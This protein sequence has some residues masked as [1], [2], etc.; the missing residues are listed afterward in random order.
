MWSRLIDL[1]FGEMAGEALLTGAWVCHFLALEDVFTENVQ[2]FNDRSNLVLLN[3]LVLCSIPS[4]IPLED[5]CYS[6]WGGLVSLLPQAFCVKKDPGCTWCILF[7]KRHF[8]SKPNHKG[9]LRAGSYGG[10][11]TVWSQVSV[12]YHSH[13]SSALTFHTSSSCCMLTWHS[14]STFTGNM[15]LEVNLSLPVS[16]QKLVVSQRCLVLPF[17]A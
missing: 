16:L 3:V 9:R 1:V 15:S 5:I 7:L 10:T 11:R 13:S 8:H 6:K 17:L 4:H 14:L 2:D 12:V